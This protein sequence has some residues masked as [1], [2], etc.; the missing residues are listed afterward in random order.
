MSS[1]RI[2]TIV[3]GRQTAGTRVRYLVDSSA[4]GEKTAVPETVVLTRWRQRKRDGYVFSGARLSPNVWRAVAL[5]FGTDA[6]LICKADSVELEAVIAS[7]KHALLAQH[8]A[9]PSVQTLQA[10]LDTIGPNRLQKILNRHTSPD[11]GDRYGT[12]DLFLFSTEVSSG[13]IADANFVEVKKPKEPVSNDQR[14][15]IAFLLSLGLRAR[16][17]RLIER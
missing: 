12:P 1:L 14:Q 7:M 16:V 10:L 17:L 15:E 2:S 5:A 4:A 9:L 3:Y 6:K 13:R 8:Y 11:H